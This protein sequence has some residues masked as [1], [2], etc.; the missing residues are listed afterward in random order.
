MDERMHFPLFQPHGL[1]SRQTLSLAWTV[2][3][4]GCLLKLHVGRRMTGKGRFGIQRESLAHGCGW[5]ITEPGELLLSLAPSL[6]PW[7][8]FSHL[9]SRVLGVQRRC[10]DFA[11]FISLTTGDPAVWPPFPTPLGLVGGA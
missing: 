10:V 6:P 5:H 11:P 4:P 7:D 1:V 8:R 3:V 9:L 2:G